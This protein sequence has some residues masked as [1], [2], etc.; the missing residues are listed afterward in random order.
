MAERTEQEQLASLVGQEG[1]EPIDTGDLL[2]QGLMASLGNPNAHQ[3]AAMSQ[4]IENNGDVATVKRVGQPKTNQSQRTVASEKLILALYETRDNLIEAFTGCKINSGLAVTLSNEI[5]RLGSC[6]IHLGGQA[7]A[8]DPLTHISGLEMPNMQKNAEEVIQRTIQCYKLG[9]IKEAKI[10]GGGKE[11]NI[12]F[13]GKDG[14]TLYQAE[15]RIIAKTW[16][17]NEAIDYVYTP[18]SGNMSVKAFENG[19]WVNKSTGKDSPY[20]VSWALNEMNSALSSAETSSSTEEV[21]SIPQN[22]HV[23]NAVDEDED[24][25]CPIR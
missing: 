22:N 8:F 20:N 24:I 5:N 15:G 21:T 9:S 10:A 16:T 2:A 1:L 11:I 25:G 4:E 3:V 18:S 14:D 6:I 12:V 23:E 13:E 19:R 7:E 17:G